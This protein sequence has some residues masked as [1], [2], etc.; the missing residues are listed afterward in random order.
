MKKLAIYPLAGAAVAAALVC[1]GGAQA[2]ATQR[3]ISDA[4]N[5]CSAMTGRVKGMGSYEYWKVTEDN[6]GQGAASGPKNK[7]FDAY[8]WKLRGGEYYDA[9]TKATYQRTGIFTWGNKTVNFTPNHF[10]LTTGKTSGGREFILTFQKDGNLVLYSHTGAAQ[11]SSN[12]QGKGV[13]LAF[14]GDRNIVVYDKNNKAVWASSWY[15]TLP[16]RGTK[17]NQPGQHWWDKRAKA[18]P[19]PEWFQASRRVTTKPQDSGA[20]RMDVS[21]RTMNDI[22]EVQWTPGYKPNELRHISA[23]YGAMTVSNWINNPDG[24]TTGSTNIAATFNN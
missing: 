24:T 3:E 9:K 11:W 22:D 17:I 7:F 1:F 21:D 2:G 14:Q 18:Q 20:I 5:T 13:R 23:N 15:W 8:H 19:A 6:R 10:C 16:R 4:R 12:T